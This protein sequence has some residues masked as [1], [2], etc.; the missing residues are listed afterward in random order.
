MIR[1]IK[2]SGTL[3]NPTKL[4]NLADAATKSLTVDSGIGSVKKLMGLA[5]DIGKVNTKN[6]TFVT[7]PVIDD[8]ADT[9]RLLLKNPDAQQLFAMVKADNSLTKATGKSKKTPSPTATTKADPA[10][11][12]VNVVNGG[13]EIGAAQE[14]VDWLQNQ[15]GVIRSSN[16]GNATTTLSKTKLEYAPNHGDQARELAG[17]M[18]LPDSA[19]KETGEDADPMAQMTLTLGKDF[20]GAGVPI[21]APTAAPSDIQ[22]IQADDKS[23]CAK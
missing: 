10:E 18:G 12:R 2:S 8:P 5:Q 15:K 19:L 23:V 4:W 1:K 14:T 9:N 22:R 21:T 11:V 6:I 7:T 13:A 20:E 17:I 3:T 16:G